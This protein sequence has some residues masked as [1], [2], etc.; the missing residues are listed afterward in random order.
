MADNYQLNVTTMLRHAARTFPETEVVYK[1]ADGT[2]ERSNYATEIKRVSRMAHA[3]A[4]AGVQAGDVVGVMDWNSR[5][6][7]ELYFA[8]P[9]LAATHL[10]LNLKLSRED[11][12][13]VVK[14]SGAQWVVVDESLLPIAEGIQGAEDVRGWIILSDRRGPEISTNLP[15]PIYLED[16]M[17]SQPEEY[18]WEEVEE[19]TAAYAGYTTGTTGRPKGIFYSHRAVCLHAWALH[20]SLSFTHRDCL[21]PVTPMFHVMTW[22]FLHAAVLAGSKLV[23]PGQYAAT[24]VEDLA[25]ALVLEEVTISNGSPAIWTPILEYFRNRPETVDLEGLRVVVAG[26]E[27]ALALMKGFQETANADIVHGYGASETSPIVAIN[28]MRKRSL[29]GLSGD[30]WWDLKRSQGL[31]SAG[32][33]IKIVALDGTELPHDGESA[34]EVYY[35]GPFITQEYFNRP[36]S[37]DSFADGW[38]RSGDVG[39][40]DAN[41]YLKLT[42]RLKDVIKSGGEWISSIDM[43]NAILD[44]PRIAEA[45]VIGVPDE[46]WD[47]RPVA[48]VVPRAGESVEADD[49]RSTLLARFA[50][51]QLPD[52]VLVVDELPRT[53]VGKLNK[54]KLRADYTS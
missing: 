11:L 53:S 6:H 36:E 28:W 9:G 12:T 44:N 25:E 29:E 4:E 49:V 15:N 10:Q 31:P 18:A 47:E 7:M 3:L 32:T 46:K 2:W 38:W 22:G 41:G 43:E 51:W 39:V 34:G 17:S 21:M 45:A 26:S 50:K 13:Y 8:L 54:K 14:H 5:R 20:T 35:K 16:L 27:P 19:T 48:Y 40:I 23:M 37:A 33:D 42:D 52:K 1:G 30:E 24:D